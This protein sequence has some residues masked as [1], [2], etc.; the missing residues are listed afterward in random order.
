MFIKPLLSEKIRNR[1]YFHSST[2]KLLDYFP[3]AILPSEYG[4]DLRENDMKD[5]LRKANVDHKQHGVTGQ[6][7]YF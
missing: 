4:G 7:N 5:W 1:V 3:R 2:E 6:P